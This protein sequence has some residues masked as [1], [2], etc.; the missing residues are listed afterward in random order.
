MIE[1]IMSL[2][3]AIEY[4]WVNF[5]PHLLQVSIIRSNISG[6]ISKEQFSISGFMMLNLDLPGLEN[7][8]ANHHFHYKG[9]CLSFLLILPKRLITLNDSPIDKSDASP[10]FFHV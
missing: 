6:Q 5:P 10:K 9:K 2:A 4:P 7:F 1:E 3:Q 8:V